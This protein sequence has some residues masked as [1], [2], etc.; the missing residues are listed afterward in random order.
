MVDKYL[1]L[2]AGCWYRVRRAV[3]L[4]SDTLGERQTDE[5]GNEFSEFVWPSHSI[6][7]AEFVCPSTVLEAWVLKQEG[8]DDG[9]WR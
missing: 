8:M 1:Y 2:V 6:L 4:F 7:S 5:F 3:V 9:C